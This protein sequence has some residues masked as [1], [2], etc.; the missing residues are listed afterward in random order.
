M[1]E[2]VHEDGVT[3]V[4]QE[5]WDDLLAASVVYAMSV[6]DENAAALKAIAECAT[7]RQRAEEAEEVVGSLQLH[8]ER[9]REALDILID[10]INSAMQAAESRAHKAND[11]YE[12]AVFARIPPFA[13]T[14]NTPAGANVVSD[15]S[16]DNLHTFA[17]P[18]GET[19]NE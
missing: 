13:D 2:P 11:V 5:D 18:E 7:W 15:K 14:A 8:N 12:E 3:P 10:I 19:E 4:T 17:S 16:T 6:K 9:L 1:S